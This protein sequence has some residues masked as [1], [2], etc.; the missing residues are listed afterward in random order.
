MVVLIWIT[1]LQ[2]T[3]HA[4]IT[5]K[6]LWHCLIY[7]FLTCFFFCWNSCNS[8]IITT[9]LYAFSQ[10]KGEKGSKPSQAC[11]LGL[12]FEVVRL[13]YVNYLIRFFKGKIQKLDNK[14]TVFG[15]QALVTFIS[16]L[17]HIWTLMWW[18]SYACWWWY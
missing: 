2:G 16:F 10:G 13:Y 12:N 4:E 7:L 6:V 15:R 5:L 17:L 9:T 14:K 1:L 18:N 11:V 3:T 8:F